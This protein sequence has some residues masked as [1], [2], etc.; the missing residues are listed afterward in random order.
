MSPL[1]RPFWVLIHRWA[2]LTLALFLA[3]AGLTGTF[4]AWEDDLEALTA[5]HWLRAAP[6]TP[7]APMLD[8]A[9]LAVAA[10]ARH[11]GMSVSYLPLSVE[12]GKTLRLRVFWKEPAKAPDWD[13]LFIDPYTGA[14]L[15][16]RRW[17]DISQGINNLLPLIY[18]L[19]E[20]L[21]VEGTGTLI[22]GT[23]ALVW[24]VDCFVGFYLTLPMRQKVP[25]GV[26]KIGGKTKGWWQRWRPSW[27]VR[28]GGSAY[29]LN[30]DLHRAGGLWVWPVL[31][32]FALSSVSFNLPTIYGPVMKALGATDDTALYA[33]LPQPR[34]IPKLDVVKAHAVGEVLA[35]QQ[36]A[37]AHDSFDA[38]RLQ[39]LYY[40]PTTGAYMYGFT[41]SGDVPDAGGASRLIFDG[42]TGALKNVAL[43]SKVPAANRFT[44]WIVSL[45]MASVWGVAWKIVTSLIGIMV[46]MLSI[47]GVVIWMKKRSARAFH[48]HRG[49]KPAAVTRPVRK[50]A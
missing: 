8:A 46:T 12:P 20:N 26:S 18:R 2:G 40:M 43:A 44:D 16:H 34:P 7:G 23:A 17:G 13:E 33:P 48:R 15:G 21:L 6:P 9:A 35:R 41:T 49:E 29:K 30:F 50:A 38:N 32:V 45:H 5:P 31:L 4:L 1:T 24:V 25:V 22:M 27:L 42:D 39:W 11:P 36:T 47:T 10:Q 3:M 28:R 37:K 19:H 14:E